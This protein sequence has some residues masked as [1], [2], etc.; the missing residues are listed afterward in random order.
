MSQRPPQN[1]TLKEDPSNVWNKVLPVMYKH[2][3]TL[4][5]LHFWPRTSLD[6]QD[7]ILGRPIALKESE[8]RLGTNKLIEHPEYEGPLTSCQGHFGPEC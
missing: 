2:P 3:N 8:A 6:G 1:I 5:Q 4:T 7:K